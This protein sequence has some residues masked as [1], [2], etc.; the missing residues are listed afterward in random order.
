MKTFI[1]RLQQ[2]ELLSELELTEIFDN[3]IHNRYSEEQVIQFLLTLN[4]KSDLYHEI[5]TLRDVIFAGANKIDG[6]EDAIDLCGTGGDNLNYLNISTATAFVVASAG[7]TVAKHGNRGVS[8]KSGSSDVL[9]ALG[10]NI[11]LERDRVKACLSEVGMAFLFAPLYHPILKNVADI[12][13]KIGTRTIFNI[14]GPLLNPASVRCQLIGVYDFNLAE[15]ICKVMRDNGS[16]RVMVVHGSN[17]ADEVTTIGITKVCEL[18][19]G[20]I[21]FWEF[22]PESVGLSN[23]SHNDL[24]GKD[25]I[26]N[27]GRIIDLLEGK[28]SAFYDNVVL[29]A[30][31]VIYLSGMKS[32]LQ[33]AIIYASDLI[34]SGRSMQKLV[35]LKEFR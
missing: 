29:N 34:D 25:P 18:N 23:N 20:E 16:K 21:K 8:S 27:A 3:I 30:A 4:D 35:Q 11:M 33:T 28:K 24:V 19:N 17:G 31:F 12:R 10:V 22:D 1:K 2:N 14:L 9:K 6:F 32:S 5:K 26:Y 13:K 7:I 15:S